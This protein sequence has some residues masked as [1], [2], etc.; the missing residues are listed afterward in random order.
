MTASTT[1]QPEI[2]FL[3]HAGLQIRYAGV[4]LLCD[5]WISEEGAF[6]HC[7]HQFPPNDFIRPESLHG[8]D[9]IYV[10]HDHGDHFDRAF[11]SAFPKERVTLIIADFLAGR[12]AEQLAAMGFPRIVRLPDWEKLRLTEAFDVTV[13]REQSLFKTDSLI[14]IEAGGVK[15]LDRNDCHILDEHREHFGRIGVDILLSQFSGAMWYPAAYDYPP[16]KQQ[17]VA[18][19]LRSG[20]IERF[21]LR[22]NSIRPRHVLHAAGPPCFL[23]EEHLHLNFSR[24]G[25]FHDQ[26]E[27]FDE[28]S[29]RLDAKLHLA[30]PGDRL[31]LE[32]GGE[33]R[34]ERERPFDFARKAET[35]ARCRDRRQASIRE[36][37]RRIAVPGDGF[38]HQF[39]KHLGGLF[40]SSKYL[41]RQSNTLARFEVTGPGG[42]CVFVD[43]RD[44]RFAM[45][46]AHADPPNYQII[47]EGPVALLLATGE[48]T[49]EDVLLS[50]RFRARRDPD[51]YNWPLLALLRYGHEP[52]LVREVEK[53]LQGGGEE[54]IV[55][56]D[57]ARQFRVQ[58]Y[59]PHTGEDLTRAVIEDGK[60]TCP[61]HRWVFDLCGGGQCVSG[62][63]V[64]LRVC[65]ELEDEE[66]D[67]EV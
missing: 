46:D 13:V 50:L 52:A 25:I 38:M 44:G 66:R 27:V 3:G 2:R 54:T 59:C 24:N 51:E 40:G 26:H 28:V 15:L 12:L 63:N 60:L 47:L 9:Y 48:E 29:Q 58:R 61:R 53:R 22:A 30:L 65:E 7:W 8:A 1:S 62:G 16:E 31:H 33:L 19:D 64:P 11:L 56:R 17:E 34:I 35:I 14:F 45:T 20:L 5:P 39:K 32:P 37:D 10:S 4:E 6:L 67:G 57:G 49:W 23:R 18:A 36:Y 41:R 55:V 42:G 43:T 21:V